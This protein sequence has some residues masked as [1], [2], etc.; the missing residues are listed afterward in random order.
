VQI[1]SSW[2]E[3]PSLKGVRANCCV[4]I[5]H[6]GEVYAKSIGELQ[7]TEH[8]ISGPVMFEISRDVCAERG[9]WTAKLDFLPNLPAE[10]LE[11]ELQRRRNTNLPMEELL[12]GILHNRLGRVLTKTAGI[13]GK[14]YASQISNAELA[15]VV[16]CVK[17]LEI[18]LT[19][20][21]GMDS[22]QVTAGGVLTDGFDPNTMESKSVSSL[23]ACGEVLDID[24]DCGGYNLQWAWSS[25]RCAG[26]HAGKETK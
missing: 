25:G 18:T 14:Q 2:P 8:G 5:L 6:N 13:K 11:K 20:P 21:L 7:L 22:A 9:K 10:V 26:L 16:A 15:E 17:G 3:L 24:G 1:K 12:T 19:E 4:E 23:Y